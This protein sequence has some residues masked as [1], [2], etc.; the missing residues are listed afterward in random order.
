ME[1]T[2]KLGIFGGTFNPIH[3]GHLQAGEEIYRRARLDKIL[4]IPAYIPPH[5][6]QVNIAPAEDRLAMLRLALAGRQ[7]F[8]PSAIE[9]EDQRT[10]YSIYTLKKI[11]R[12]YPQ[13]E[14][15]F[16]IG[17]DAFL[18]IET[19]KDYEHV[20]EES[21]FLVMSRPGYQLAE[22]K[23]ILPNRWQSRIAWLKEEEKESRFSSDYTIYL[24]EINALPISASEI[25]DKV[26]R[27][28]SIAHL[29]PP[30]V[31]DYIHR[32]HLYQDGL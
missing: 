10:S 24:V 9:I 20:L 12:L 16:I 1:R 18:E 29:V 32:H 4:F 11:K 15:F 19:W 8:V 22:V 3:L 31:A 13:A 27:G 7:E 14:P 5:K 17:V 2:S 28:E 26:R 6:K 21:N 30:A 23:E 25:R